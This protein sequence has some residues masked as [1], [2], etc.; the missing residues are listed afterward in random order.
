[1]EDFSKHSGIK[2]TFS[3][4]CYMFWILSPAE[5]NTISKLVGRRVTLHCKNTSISTLSQLTWKMNGNLLF[6]F[7][8]NFTLHTSNTSSKLSINM[9]LSESQLYALVIERVQKSHTGNYT[10][11]TNT[12]T[13]LWEE[14][15]ELIIT[16]GEEAEH[17]KIIQFAVVI[18]VPCVSC[19]ILIIAV[20]VLR[21]VY[22]QRA[23]NNDHSPTADMQQEEPAEVIYDNCLNNLQH[24]CYNQS[25]HYKPRAH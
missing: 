17:R 2:R 6:S 19:L 7:R 9:S 23:E 25:Y 3:L 22:K 18:G 8:P 16:E 21:R 10:C 4:I 24:P 14:K 5:G 15:W 1:M 20:I 12:L 13:G 11:E